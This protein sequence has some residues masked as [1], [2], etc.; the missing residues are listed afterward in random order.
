M[1]KLTFAVAMCGAVLAGSLGAKAI[2]AS[3]MNPA[4]VQAT[5]STLAV[6]P[7]QYYRYPYH[8]H[9]HRHYHCYYRHGRRYCH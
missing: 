4:L 1:R 9:Y 8:R 2:P 7:V 3:D 5:T 6:Q